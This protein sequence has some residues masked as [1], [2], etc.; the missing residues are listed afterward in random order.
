M[1]NQ[2]NKYKVSDAT[3]R[4]LVQE[5][6]ERIVLMLSP[7][8]PHITQVMWEG[9]GHSDAVIDYSWPE[10]DEQA[11]VQSTVQLMVQVNGKL[12]GKIDV[13]VDAD[14]DSVKAMAQENS[15]VQRFLEDKTIRK[16]IVVKGRL[17]NI[18]VG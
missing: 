2:I 3:D 16:I 6:L 1:L 15:N 18:V 13:D 14:D 8:A 11:L 5:A 7:I 12:R 4:L 9:L 17:V 10:V